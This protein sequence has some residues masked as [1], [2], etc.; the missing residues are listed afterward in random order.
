MGR[1]VVAKLVSERKYGDWRDH[2]DWKA[3]RI[4]LPICGI[5][6]LFAASVFF[7]G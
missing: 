5:V 4:V 2:I 6:I 3:A 1:Y 7:G